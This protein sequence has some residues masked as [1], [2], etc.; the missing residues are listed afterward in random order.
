MKFFA[1]FGVICGIN[2]PKSIRNFKKHMALYFPKKTVATTILKGIALVVGVFALLAS[3]LFVRLLMGP[4]D[5]NFVRPYVEAALR[6]EQSGFSVTMDKLVLEWMPAKTSLLLG[7]KNAGVYAADGNLIVSID[8]AAIG[9]SKS[10]ILVGRIVP[11]SLI[12][13]KPTLRVV[14]HEDNSLDVGL[15]PQIIQNNAS[16]SEKIE[17]DPLQKIIALVAQPEKGSQSQSTF[18]LLRLLDIQDARVI[19]DDRVI[20]MNWVLPKLNT[21]MTR[22]RDGLKIDIDVAFAEMQK[23]IPA[24]KINAF[25][26]WETRNIEIDTVLE[27]FEPKFLAMRVPQLSMLKGMNGRM[28]ARLRMVMSETREILN[29]ELTSLAALGSFTIPELSPK[30]IPYKNLG[31]FARY[32]GEARIFEL[33]RAQVSLNDKATIMATA[34]FDTQ[35]NT[36]DGPL[37]LT[38]DRIAQADIGPLWPEALKQEAAYEWVVDRL[39]AG[40]FSNVYAQ[41]DFKP[42]EVEGAWSTTLDNVIAGFDFENMT[43]NYRA[44]LSPVINAKG[45]GVFDMKA[46]TLN[47]DVSSAN[48]LD[49]AMS[50]AKI[51]LSKIIEK[52]K[53]LADINIKLNGPLKSGLTFI[54]DE[55]IA[56]NTPIDVARTEGLADIEVQLDFPTHPDLKVEEVKIAAQGSMRDVKLPK[57]FK[58]MTLAGGPFDLSIKDELFTAKGKGQIDGRDIDLEYQEYLSAAGKDFSSKVIASVT[59]DENLRQKMGMDLS[60][61]LEGA[62]PVVMTYVAKPDKTARAEVA[63]DLTPADLFIEPFD[64]QK[65]PGQAG[66]AKLTAHLKNDVLTDISDL[67]GTAPGFKL[68]TTT[69]SFREHQGETQ[70]SG[71]KISRFSLGETVGNGQFE[72]AANGFLK[73][74][75]NGSLFDLRSFLNNEPA[76]VKPY[77]APPMQVSIKVDRMKTTEEDH[78]EYAKIYAYIDNTGRFNQLELDGKVGAGDLFIRYKPDETGKRTF[79]LEAQDAGATL[80]AFDIYGDIVGGRLVIYGEPIKGVFD[81]NLIGRAE[82]TNFKVV[83][84]PAL[85]K[86][87]G[88]M[89]LPGVTQVMGNEGLSFTKLES[90]FDWLYRPKG[91]L[92]VLKDGGTSGNSLGLTFDGT[93]D[94]AA[95]MI[96]VEGT[97][98]PLSG[99]NKIIGSIPLVGDIITGGTGSLIAATY[100]MKGQGADVKTFVNPLSVLTPGI[101]RRILFEGSAPGAGEKP[102]AE[103]PAQ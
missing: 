37:R 89:S 68:E 1:F 56:V 29:A 103:V 50:E 9:L 4:L 25:L 54:K 61:F 36:L 71:G 28:D 73:I 44:P 99:I 3:L 17:E 77:T 57:V 65:P 8:E 95:Q 100:S 31:L 84:A 41:L 82:M 5:M 43:V 81:R 102:Q 72:I 13:K 59:V 69:L 18:Y 26:R 97:I 21:V 24:L 79:R 93:F 85:A 98:I 38:I 16:I 75:M 92:L 22:G 101:L 67:T 39:S 91:S 11:T 64:Y 80:K 27:Y 2:K 7:M 20:D 46:E 70:L 42:V 76:G 33:Q 51:K 15:A 94:N 74:F 48:V 62:A 35:K 58:D 19:V 12:L 52:G 49:L 96:D 83:R 14:R 47:V 86:L 53:G 63:V 30:P 34:E 87:L 66:K 45:T 6:D 23:R 32:D 90:R 10:R 40:V 55:P 60:L 78:V 88:A